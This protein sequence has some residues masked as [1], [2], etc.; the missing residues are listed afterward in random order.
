MKIGRITF[1][2]IFNKDGSQEEKIE[3]VD[4]DSKRSLGIFGIMDHAQ[5]VVNLPMD[6]PEVK[7]IYKESFDILEN[8]K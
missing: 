4:V 1:L 5:C 6:M 3:I 7:N 8:S 2:H